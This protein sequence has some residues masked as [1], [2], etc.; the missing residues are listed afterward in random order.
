MFS[1]PNGRYLARFFTVLPPVTELDN[2]PAALESGRPTILILDIMF[3]RRSSLDLLGDWVARFPATQV[4][5]ASGHPESAFVARAFALGARG[6]VYKGDGPDTLVRA[7]KDVF[8]GLLF[9]PPTLAAAAH[10]DHCHLQTPLSP[11]ERDVF[12]HLHSGMTYT[13]A[14]SALDISPRTVEKHAR[15]IRMKMA[16]KQPAQRILWT[17]IGFDNV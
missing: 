7:V 15:A 9:V 13:E 5:V 3:G 6:F 11:R 2:I 12:G 10:P 16:I 8:R 1:E 17:K 4:I 14:A